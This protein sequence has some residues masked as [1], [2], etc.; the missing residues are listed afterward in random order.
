MNRLM[1]DIK[2]LDDPFSDDDI[3][4]QLEEWWDLT[5][6]EEEKMSSTATA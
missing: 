1:Q 2:R 4:D 6:K 5:A 3:I